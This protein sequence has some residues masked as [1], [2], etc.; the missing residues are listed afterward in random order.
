MQLDNYKISII[1][2]SYLKDYPNS[3]KNPEIK[4]KR[5]VNSFLNQWNNNAELIIVSDSCEITMNIYNEFYKDYENIKCIYV[6]NNQNKMYETINGDVY[7]RGTPRQKGLEEASGEIIAYMDS[8]DFLLPNFTE[9]ILTNYLNSMDNIYWFVN[10]SWYDNINSVY[11]KEYMEMMHINYNKKITIDELD[12]EW[13]VVE[14]NEGLSLIHYQPWTL[15]HRKSCNVQWEDSLNISE[16]IKFTSNIIN[17]Y[18]G[19]IYN[20]PCYIRCHFKNVYDY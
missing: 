6:E 11:E 18:E 12:S 17:N 5:A 13:V 4:F 8:D 19:K 1:M 14:P 10:Q 7:Y 20:Y 9:I 3:R 2:Q 16:D 15:T